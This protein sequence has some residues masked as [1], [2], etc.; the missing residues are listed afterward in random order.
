MRNRGPPT[1][2]PAH[3]IDSGLLEARM[4][5]ERPCRTLFIRNIAY[6]TR[7]DELTSLFE[8]FGPIRKLFNLIPKRGMAFI[9]F[10][11]IR[12]AEEAKK[13]LHTSSLHDRPIDVHYS[14][15]KEDPQQEMNNRSE[16]INQGTLFLTF[17]GNPVPTV[18]RLKEIFGEHG[19]VKE[20]RDCRTNAHVFFVEFFDSR[21]ATKALEAL[22]GSSQDGGTIEL[23]YSLP[24][25]AAR[26]YKAQK[27]AGDAGGRRGDVSPSARGGG[28]YAEG[29]RRGRG[30]SDGFGEYSGGYDDS[31]RYMGDRYDEMPGPAR[32]RDVEDFP[33]P[34]GGVDGAGSYY[35]GQGYGGGVVAGPRDGR[36]GQQRGGMMSAAS[37]PAALTAASMFPGNAAGGVDQSLLALLQASAAGGGFASGLGAEAA[38]RALLTQQPSSS[39]SQTSMGAALASY[40]AGLNPNAASPAPSNAGVNALYATSA[41]PQPSSAFNGLPAYAPSQQ[42]SF[43]NPALSNVQQLISHSLP[44]AGPNSLPQVTQSNQQANLQSVVQLLQAQAR[45]GGYA[46]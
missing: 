34:G 37:P 33:Y 44:A 40:G 8:R 16:D 11:D 22:N 35:G 2:V 46:L 42:Y 23:R 20:I 4:K 18:N 41:M 31:A 26:A 32:G 24:D 9:T 12:H 6:D 7:E 15:P 45:Q 14:L 38:L 30:Y 43:P 19:E 25:T 21:D 3:Q 36:S 27:M 39:I 10:Y 1:R 13:E 17:K 28:G 29:H 5:R